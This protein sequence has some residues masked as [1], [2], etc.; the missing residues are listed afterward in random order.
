MRVAFAIFKYFPH[1][2]IARDL[3]K[4]VAECLARG[5]QVRIYAMRWEGEPPPGVEQV[6]LPPRGFRSHVQQRRFAAATAD[7]FRRQSLDLLVGMNKMPGLHVYFAGDSCFETKVRAQR[8]W[9][10]RLTPRYRH[11]AAFESAVFAV[12]TR[13]R[14]L[15]ISATEVENFKAA[16]GTPAHRFHM[17]PPG[18][19][20]ARVVD[21]DRQATARRARLRSELG[22]ADAELLLLFVG[23]GFIKKGL[24]RALRGVAALPARLRERVRLVVVGDD[25]ASRFRRMARR[26]GLADRVS[27]L[28]G[29]D[30]VPMLLR[31]ADALAL[32]AYDEAAGKVILESVLAGV[33]TLATANCGYASYIEQADAGLVTPEPFQQERYNADLERLLTSAER[34]HWSRRG[35][36][37]GKQADLHSLAPRAVG[38]L[39]RFAAGGGTP[40]VAF[41]VYR[42]TP[43]EPNYRPLI[44]VMEAC[45]DLGMNVR[46]LAQTWQGRLPAGVE[47][48]RVPVAA[49]DD[50]K[51]FARYAGWVQEALRH[52]PD[53]CVVGFER[54]PGIDFC[55]GEAC[56]GADRQ[57]PA[58]R[59]HATGASKRLA[60]LP[61]GLTATPPCGVGTPAPRQPRKAV[62]LGPDTVVFAMSGGDLVR[63]GFERLL[64]SWGKLPTE[65]RE[66]CQL[67]ALG[68]LQEG[69]TAAARIL[70]VQNQVHLLPGNAT[71]HELIQ[72]ADV[73]VELPYARSSSGW[74]FDA[75]AAGRAVVTH[76]WTTEAALVRHAAAGVVL[77]APFRQRDC[78]RA[79]ANLVADAAQ[80][81]RWQT[82][83]AR[84]AA[85]PAHYG[86]ATQAAQIIAAEARRHGAV[87]A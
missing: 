64:T 18:V 77:A 1:G 81:R 3:R 7:H 31:S 52:A 6:L 12:S 56:G 25:K 5:H 63:H 10:Y 75:M 16:Y 19:E 59:Q 2:G 33:P 8:P 38:L 55:Y 78:N 14:V 32:P 13:T 44:P 39:E 71:F 82:N 62:R 23:S 37:F 24:D 65:L 47:L 66:R 50:G 11:F 29:R 22:V 20:C 43:A 17:L 60:T 72:A 36:G 49:M 45:R 83:A 4:I 30:D 40:S 54:I 68:G 85:D 48:V 35:R 79:L 57:H 73:F 84:F 15:A 42:Y 27:F 69:F 34:D 76:E 61:I 86:H 51:R 21:D 41:C 28:G 26:L 80:R 58:D 74:M 46:I 67:L 9:L 87:F 53:T 70:G